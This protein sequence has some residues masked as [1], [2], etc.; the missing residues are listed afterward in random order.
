MDSVLY[1]CTSTHVSLQTRSSN[2][3][4]FP[5]VQWLRLCAPNGG[6]PSFIPDQGTISH[7]PNSAA[8]KKKI[9]LLELYRM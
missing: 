8:K 9:L 2:Y 4:T 7:M 1:A 5:V 3:G 6:G